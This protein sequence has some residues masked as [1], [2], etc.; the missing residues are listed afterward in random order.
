MSN[1]KKDLKDVL[2]R[3]INLLVSNSKDPKFGKELVEKLLSVKGQIDS[4]ATLL[5]IPL[6]NVVE[7]LEGETFEM[8]FTKDGTAIYH[9][10]GG[11]D[12][13]CKSQFLCLN[14]ALIDIVKKSKEQENDS[15]EDKKDFEDFV[16]A[17]SY[18]LNIP[19]YAFSDSNTLFEFANMSISKIREIYEREFGKELQEETPEQDKAFEGAMKSVEYLGELIKEGEEDG[20]QNQDKD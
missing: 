20:E 18:V 15:E 1:T 19:L 7:K 12:I 10:K 6:D 3:T 9:L 8:M 4:T 16:K 5:H 13:V 14:Q 17:T 2:S 11:L